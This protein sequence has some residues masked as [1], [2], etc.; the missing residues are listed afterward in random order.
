M[1][2]LKRHQ[3]DPES[4]RKYMKAVLL[5]SFVYLRALCG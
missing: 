4:S 2:D 1:N 5:I 3:A